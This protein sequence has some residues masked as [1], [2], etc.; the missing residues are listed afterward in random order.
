MMVGKHNAMGEETAPPCPCSDTV[1]TE[2]GDEDVEK[3]TDSLGEN[4]YNGVGH[5]DLRSC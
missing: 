2:E 4:F 5:D 3:R 1:R